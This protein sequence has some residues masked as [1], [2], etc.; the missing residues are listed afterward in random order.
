MSAL[1]PP[2]PI[3]EMAD[4]DFA[5]FQGEV[6][7]AREPVVMR[8][9]V[10]D[11]PAV[12]AALVG[13]KA[14]VDYLVGCG[15]RQPVQ[16]IAARPEEGGRF[17][18]NTDLTG[19]NFIKGRGRLD[20]FLRDLLSAKA[21][22][23]PPAMAV[24]S[25][26]I[27]QVMPEFAEANALPLLRG[28]EPRIWI[29]NRIR[30]APHYDIKENVACC[31]AGRRR[32]TLFP[33]DQLANMYPGPFELTPAGTP[34]S[35]VDPAAPDLERY[36]RFAEAWAKAQQ[37]ELEPGDAIYIPYTWWH[38]VESLDPVSIL[39]NYWWSDAPEGTA[40]PFDALLHAILAYRHLPP[41]DRAVWKMML[42]HYVFDAN[43]DPAAH[44]PD[45]AR[46]IMSPA[47]PG[48]FARLRGTLKEMLGL[49]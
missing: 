10:R 4:V 5:R 33:P 30:V 28:V 45:H 3:R 48:L 38:G 27:R 12:A 24:Q 26:I 17:F 15:P 2:A 18:Y 34:V 19:L 44:L 9:L 41:D 7:A 47:S 39:V 16:A 25:E 8:G 42:D 35:M 46:G 20:E 22:D 40:P 32:F 1:P 13:D 29:G 43:G 49:L 37:A 6:R 11:W 23:R 14:I 36:P 31:V 21:S